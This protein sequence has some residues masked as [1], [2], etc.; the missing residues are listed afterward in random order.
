MLLCLE[1]ASLKAPCGGVMSQD[2]GA[3]HVKE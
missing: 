1:A 2:Q 3:K